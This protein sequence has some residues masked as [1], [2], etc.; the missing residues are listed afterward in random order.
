MVKWK[1]ME[2]CKKEKSLI[3]FIFNVYNWNPLIIWNRYTNSE[4]FEDFTY[5]VF[6]IMSAIKWKPQI[7]WIVGNLI[8]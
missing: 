7:H 3:F 2:Y 1:K 6:M 4:K 5:L 8:Q